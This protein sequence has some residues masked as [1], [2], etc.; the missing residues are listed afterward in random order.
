MAELP[1][2]DEE[3]ESTT[4]YVKNLAFATTD[5][6][7]RVGSVSDLPWSPT[8][9]GDTFIIILSCYAPVRNADTRVP[10][11][12]FFFSEMFPDETNRVHYKI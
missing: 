8:P 6:T 3:A 4:I 1:T 9:C 11:A 5:A 2:G 10:H 7:L 12:Y